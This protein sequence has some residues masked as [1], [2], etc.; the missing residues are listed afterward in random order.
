M[1]VSHPRLLRGEGHDL[2]VEDLDAVDGTPVLDIAPW[3]VKFVPRGEVSQ[4]RWPGEMLSNYG[5]QPK[6]EIQCWL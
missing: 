1:A 3:F 5:K 6:P 2:H 4:P